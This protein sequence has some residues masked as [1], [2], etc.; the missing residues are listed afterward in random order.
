M[1]MMRSG[2]IWLIA[3]CLLSAC[4]FLEQYERAGEECCCYLSEHDN[5][6]SDPDDCLESTRLCLY[7]RDGRERCDGEG[8]ESTFLRFD[9]SGVRA[10]TANLI[11]VADSNQV[12]GEPGTPEPTCL[13]EC[14]KEGPFCLRGKIQDAGVIQGFKRS[15]TKLFEAGSWRYKKT[16]LM[17]D[18]KVSDDPCERSDIFRNG[19]ELLNIG[20]ECEL[21]LPMAGG[22][23]KRSVTVSVPRFVSANESNAPDGRF[24]KFPAD[25]EGPRILFSDLNYQEDFG[26]SMRSLSIIENAAIAQTEKGC[27]MLSFSE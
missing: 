1:N 23:S 5:Y 4:D 6:W 14:N 20:K 18:Y 25:K 2:M 17:N 9:Q 21:S 7:G 22:E 13:A 16:E 12:A 3:A 27:L 10:L 24:I 26:G 8:Q 19:N 15:K 11:L